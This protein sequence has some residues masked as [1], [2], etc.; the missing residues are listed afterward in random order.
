MQ[1]TKIGGARVNDS[2]ADEAGED[3][4]AEVSDVGLPDAR[5]AR[6]LAPPRSPL[7][8]ARGARQ[9]A[10]RAGAT[11]ALIALA[12]VC[13]L[14]TYPMIRSDVQ[15]LIFGPPGAPVIAP[16]TDVIYLLP[17]APGVAV[18][19]D[20]H[21]LYGSHTVESA[22]PLRLVPGRHTFTWQ[23]EPFARQ[24]CTVSVPHVETDTCRL[25]AYLQR[26]PHGSSPVILSS[27][28][29][30]YTMDAA[31]SSQLRQALQSALDASE[32][33]A[34][35]RVG[36][37][38]Y[39]AT[40]GFF[41]QMTP[42]AMPLTARLHFTLL[43]QFIPPEP[44]E[45]ARDVQPC[46]FLGQNCALLCTLPSQDVNG[47]RP[48]DEWDVAAMVSA[49]W[50]YTRPDGT[51]LLAPVNELNLGFA[52]GFFRVRWTGSEWTAEAVFG[53]AS[54]IPI[55]DDTMCLPARG[56][57]FQG[58]AHEVFLQPSRY[59]ARYAASANPTDGCVAEIVDRQAASGAPGSATDPAL[60][61][62]R[63]GAIVAVNN[64]ARA[65]W[66][67]LPLADAVGRALAERLR[68]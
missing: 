41:G 20:G 55:A 16:A 58:P 66:P 23:G 29:T 50:Q 49:S 15:R 35:V 48:R 6:P 67:G 1:H 31:R 33:D 22:Q 53:H 52:L 37:V 18:A 14:A 3:F 11:G 34:L 25:F 32:Q 8:P 2:K 54:G 45:V 60:F 36:E 12:L 27:H 38:Y 30:M 51:R 21:H 4:A 24:S 56:W 57:L 28:E 64:A 68:Q 9:Q 61:L 10:W 19:L 63:F 7:L 42:A 40:P 5:R 62:A 59:S 17:N 65:L 39:A 44:C 13:V 46:R 26:G 47:P 43:I